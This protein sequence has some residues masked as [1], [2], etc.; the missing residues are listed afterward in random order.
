MTCVECI[1]SNDTGPIQHAFLASEYKSS[2]RSTLDNHIQ[3]ITHSHTLVAIRPLEIG[4]N[5]AS[6]NLRIM[7]IRLQHHEERL[8]ILLSKRET[9]NF[10]CF[11]SASEL[12]LPNDRRLLVKLVPTIAVRGSRVVRAV[13]PHGR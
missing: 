4:S 13:D 5:I 7:K 6:I 1:L 10:R 8:E 2:P 11:Y 12:Y 9:N 3:I